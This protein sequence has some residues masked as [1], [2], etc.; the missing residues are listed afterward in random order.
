MVVNLGSWINQSMD[1]DEKIKARI[2]LARRAFLKLCSKQLNIHLCERLAKCYEWSVLF[3]SFMHDS[4][5]SRWVCTEG[6]SNSREQADLPTKMYSSVLGTMEALNHH[7][8][9]QTGIL[10]TIDEWT[11]L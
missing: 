3:D 4:M 2:K 5:H 7:R 10:R 1:Q 6:C 9:A 11:A 8:A